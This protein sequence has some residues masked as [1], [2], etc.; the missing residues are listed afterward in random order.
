VAQTLTEEWK[1]APG[2]LEVVWFND[3]VTALECELDALDKR[4]ERL[5]GKP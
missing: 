1:M 3:E 5:E 2:P 4:I